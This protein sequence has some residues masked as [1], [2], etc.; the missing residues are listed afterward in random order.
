MRTEPP[1]GDRERQRETRSTP[2]SQVPTKKPRYEASLRYREEM[3]SKN[4]YVAELSVEISEHDKTR[5]SKNNKKEP[6]LGINPTAC[7]R[8]SEVAYSLPPSTFFWLCHWPGQST[9]VG[10]RRTQDRNERWDVSRLLI[11]GNCLEPSGNDLRSRLT[12]VR[13][14]VQTTEPHCVSQHV[15][16]VCELPAAP[17]NFGKTMH[18]R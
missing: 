14:Y 5:M 10:I 9:D 6:Q 16:G 11:G 7:L 1:F 15:T 2:N 12:S 18:S 8:R 17:V 13:R 3:K 4:G